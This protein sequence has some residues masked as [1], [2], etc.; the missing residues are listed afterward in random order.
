MNPIAGV[1]HQPLV[2]LSAPEV[3]AFQ[4]GVRILGFRPGAPLRITV[5]SLNGKVAAVKN[6]LCNAA[7][8]TVSRFWP[9]QVVFLNVEQAGLPVYR[10][11]VL[12]L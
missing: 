7:I 10:K 1:I 5:F 11:I 12:P 6:L 9:K 8:F 2:Q 4:N 3:V